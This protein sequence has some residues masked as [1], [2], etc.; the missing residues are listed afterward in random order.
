MMENKTKDI[1]YEIEDIMPTN[2]E[3]IEDALSRLGDVL[4][5]EEV[6]WSSIEIKP[7]SNG[8]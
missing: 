6:I 3:I 7:G 1:L 5:A 8:K 2:K 4:N